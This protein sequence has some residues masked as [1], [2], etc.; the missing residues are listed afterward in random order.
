MPSGF[1]PENYGVEGSEDIHGSPGQAIGW[2]HN[3]VSVH[4]QIFRKGAI[5]SICFFAPK[6]FLFLVVIYQYINTHYQ[7]ITHVAPKTPSLPYNLTT[8]V[9]LRGTSNSLSPSN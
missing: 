2:W 8:F 3:R 7:R 4:F 5:M 9:T 1:S 6:M